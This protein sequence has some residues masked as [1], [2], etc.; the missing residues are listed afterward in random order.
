MFRWPDLWW[1]TYTPK[2]VDMGY[3]TPAE[4]TE[5]I[6]DL[7]AMTRSST[8]YWVCPPVFEIVAEKP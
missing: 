1:R 8:D 6:A 2:L 3:L 5:V 4:G 7:D